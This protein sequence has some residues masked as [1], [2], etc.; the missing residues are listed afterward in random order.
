[1]LARARRRL[2][3]VPTTALS[4]AIEKRPVLAV[5]AYAALLVV[6]MYAVA[7]FALAWTGAGDSLGG[8]GSAAGGGIGASVFRFILGGDGGGGGGGRAAGTAGGAGIGGS[9]PSLVLWTVLPVAVLAGL[10][11]A[12]A[13]AVGYKRRTDA[14][15]RRW[16]WVGAWRCGGGGEESRKGSVG[17]VML[18][19]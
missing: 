16:G 4:E 10:A 15:W 17:N 19:F 1:M 5:A 6:M 11:P 2:F 13:F 12:V 7:A 3:P 14:Y 8:V 9:V 18:V